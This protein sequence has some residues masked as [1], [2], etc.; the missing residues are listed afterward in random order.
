MP[1]VPAPQLHRL[2]LALGLGLAACTTVSPR[3]E[4]YRALP[5]ETR[6]LYDRYHLFM[7]D[8]LEE[9]FF[10][11][12]SDEARRAMVVEMHV[13]QKLA[14]YPE[15]TRD[16]IWS[17]QVLAGMDKE[18][19]FYATGKPTTIERPA[20]GEP[21]FGENETWFYERGTGREDFQVFIQRGVVQSVKKSR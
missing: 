17:R 10:A 8:D 15:A 4:A 21:G 6:A 2:L 14:R 12:K 9:R 13:E 1:P 16:A 20:K 3:L 19:V 11:A 5:P 18:A 7:T